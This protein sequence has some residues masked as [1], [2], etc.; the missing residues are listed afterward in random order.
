M[1][2][3]L[4]GGRDVRR[5]AA[6]STTSECADGALCSE[7]P[8]SRPV[9][10]APR[11]LCNRNVLIMEKVDVEVAGLSDLTRSCSPGPRRRVLGTYR[12]RMKTRRRSSTRRQPNQ[13]PIRQEHDSRR[14]VAHETSRCRRRHQMMMRPTKSKRACRRPQFE[15]STVVVVVEVDATTWNSHPTTLPQ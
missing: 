15:I 9:D 3:R 1:D 4:G 10:H 12:Q 11:H 7:P 6:R 13:R 5:C 14:Q 2:E 8:P